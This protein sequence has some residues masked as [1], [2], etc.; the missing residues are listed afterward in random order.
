MASA[1]GGSLALTLAIGAAALLVILRVAAYFHVNAL[2]FDS[3]GYLDVFWRQERWKWGMRLAAGALAG[4]FLFFNIRLVVGTLGAIQIKRRF[5]DLEIAEQLPRSVVLW[6]AAAMSAFVGLWFGATISEGFGIQA[7][8][9]AQAPEW[10]VRDPIFARDLSFYVFTLPILW[11][12]FFYSVGVL[13]IAFTACLGGY[14]ATGAVRW[15]RNLVMG[16]LPRVH[17]GALMAAFLM[18]LACYF[19][20]RRYYLLMDGTSDVGQGIF[21]YTDAQARL[22]ALKAMSVLTLGAA[23]TVFW[24]AWK[25]R[26]VPVIAGLA[27]VVGGW[28]L[29]VEFYPS[30][31]QRFRVEPNEIAREAPYI[32][33]NIEFTRMGFGLDDMQRRPFDYAPP[34]A[35]DWDEV[36]RQMDGLPVW[37]AEPLLT[38]FQQIEARFRYY[39]F[40]VAAIDRYPSAQGA[41]VAAIAVREVEPNGIEDPSWQN[42]H[43]SERYLSG[44]GVVVADAADR[45][46]QGWPLVFLSPSEA[47]VQPGAPESLALKNPVVFFGTRG[48][49]Y[50]IINP[51]STAFLAPDSTPGQPGI[52]FPEGIL[53][54]SLARKLSFAWQFTE[55]NLL[56]ASE[57]S[58]TSRMVIHRQVTERAHEIFPYAHYPEPPLPVIQD[59]RLV[60]V[61]DGFTAS[62]MLPLGGR[63]ELQPNRSYSWVRN[64]L[65]V[66][67]DAV[68]GDV[69]FYRMPGSDPILEAFDRG[70]PGLLRPFDELAPGL[71]DHLR[72]S[73]RLLDLQA[74]VLLV[75]HQEDPAQFYAQQDLWATPTELMQGD[76]PVP[77]R[78]EYGMWT[79][80]GESAESFLL[81]T[82]FVPAARQN[83]AAILTGRVGSDGRRELFLYDVAVDDQAPGPRQ[84][85]AM[86][87][88]DPVISQQFSLWRQSGSRVWTGHLNVIPQGNHLLYME[89]V[90]LAAEADAIPELRRFVVGDGK[91]VAMEPTLVEALAAFG[92]G[93]PPAR[94][95][96]SDLPVPTAGQR[97][98]AEALR[99]LQTA[100]AR[101]RAG[102]WPG[103]GTALQ[104]LRDLLERLEQDASGAA[105]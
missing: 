79:L 92:G 77:Y 91:T 35:T 22:P 100:E 18:L 96:L 78:P 6:G 76:S 75:Y 33:M 32:A 80:P 83:L 87:E 99:L 19:W 41:E 68:S 38:A 93:A 66:V 59:G 88:Q 31:V 71:R 4:A 17:L 39:E 65:R 12:V 104:E 23:V 67:V 62:R 69:V 72:Y 45:T 14:A 48:Q 46:V 36:A 5:G 37:S 60:W 84:I 10:G 103:F 30:L 102:D 29:G 40:P 27:A 25:N 24:G 85:E 98:P 53:L 42:V 26:A 89:S 95:T 57:V 50:A 86:V 82:T 64:S 11:V 47:R 61:L 15:G 73:R 16:R 63:Y 97:W 81:T 13:F 43:L 94:P 54:S 20:F 52:D 101:L 105:R 1:R 58:A 2:W 21:G 3:V 90:F 55:K 28:I 49:E 34:P 70:F 8:V 56:L 51:S 9:A 74:Q 7:L 44:M